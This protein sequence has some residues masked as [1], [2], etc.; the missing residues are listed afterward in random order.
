MTRLLQQAALIAL[1]VLLVACGGGGG[2]SGD[3]DGTDDPVEDTVEDGT[4]D[5]ADDPVEDPVEDAPDDPVPDA[6]EDA[7]EDVA[8]DTPDDAPSSGIVGDACTGA[9][10]CGGIPATDITCIEDLT[11][12]GGYTITFPGGYCSAECT[13]DGDCGGDATCER[14]G[15]D[16]SYCLDGC[17]ETSDCRESE[18]Y[19][20]RARMGD[21]DTFCLPPRTGTP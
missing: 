15:T 16:I 12:A 17:T 13:E 11:I 19:E 9:D 8:E 6:E 20:C 2:G 14:F 10:D 1:P 5:P 18:G 4:G 21:T 3:P 7:G